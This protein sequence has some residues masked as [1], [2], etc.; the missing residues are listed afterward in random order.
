MC[1][2]DYFVG[3]HV[4]NV[5]DFIELPTA[6]CCYLQMWVMGERFS[7]SQNSLVQ[8]LKEKNILKEE[9]LGKY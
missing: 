3:S 9:Y 7:P 8:E 5:Y 1:C 2:I 4:S 6:Q